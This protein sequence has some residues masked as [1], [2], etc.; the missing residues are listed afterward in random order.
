LRHWLARATSPADNA[1][2]VIKVSSGVP[3]RA[4]RGADFP[5]AGKRNGEPESSSVISLTWVDGAPTD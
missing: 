1:R 5:N 2:L 3:G 4:A